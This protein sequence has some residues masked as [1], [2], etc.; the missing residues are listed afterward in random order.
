MVSPASLQLLVVDLLYS[1]SRTAARIYSGA[2]RANRLWISELSLICWVVIA[3][4]EDEYFAFV[5]PVRVLL[6]GGYPVEF[7]V[8]PAE[9]DLFF[10]LV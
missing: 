2:Y 9:P 4:S 6:V 3:C 10:Q 5:V 8:T 1:S 7:P